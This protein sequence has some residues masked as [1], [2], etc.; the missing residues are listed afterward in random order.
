MPQPFAAERPWLTACRA[1]AQAPHGV[2][3][4]SEQLAALARVSALL[5]G[6]AIDYWLF[7]GWA[8]DVYVGSVTRAH[9]DVD[10]AVWL[11]DVPRVEELL[12]RDGWRHAPEEGEDGGT[13]YERRQVRLELTFLLRNGEG[14]AFTPFRHGPGVWPD[15]SF[16][17]D[18]GFLHGVRPRLVAFATLLS[19][20]GTPRDEP[21]DAAK[22]RADFARL[23]RLE[24]SPG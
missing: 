17:D 8:V 24:P 15:G 21:E 23:S 2:D 18:V 16:G 6:A 22:D 12:G 19:G 1:T 13:G 3:V 10:I 11:D 5:D 7:G 9:D 14:R 4:A 20:K